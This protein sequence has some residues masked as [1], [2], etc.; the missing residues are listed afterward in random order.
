ML[1]TRVSLL[2]HFTIRALWFTQ[3]LDAGYKLSLNNEKASRRSQTRTSKFNK[4]KLLELKKKSF[5]RLRRESKKEKENEI[6]RGLCAMPRTDEKKWKLRFFFTEIL[7]PVA[8]RSIGLRDQTKIIISNIGVNLTV[9]VVFLCAKKILLIWI[10]NLPARLR[11]FAEKRVCNF[12]RYF[13]CVKA[14]QRMQVRVPIFKE[15]IC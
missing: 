12:H 3:F 8:A 9:V 13:L 2:S 11:L 5:Y 14:S 6:A 7:V 10:K 1:I 4:I 15:R